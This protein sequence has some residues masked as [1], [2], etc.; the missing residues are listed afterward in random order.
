MMY[1]KKEKIREVRYTNEERLLFSHL[2][3]VLPHATRSDI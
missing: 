3:Y 1:K 2:I